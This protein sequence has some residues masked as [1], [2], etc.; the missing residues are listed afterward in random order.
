MRFTLAAA[1]LVIVVLAGCACKPATSVPTADEQV[2]ITVGHQIPT[3]QTWGA[4][5]IKNQRLFERHLD[6]LVPDHNI[7]VEW[8]N[9]ETGP[10][11]NN[12]MVARKIHIA[13]MGDMPLLANG[14]I[15]QSSTT[16]TSALVALDGKGA[17]GRNQAILVGHDSSIV[18]V[19][20]LD[21]KVIAV[22][23]GTSAH[24]MALDVLRQFDLLDR[25][26]LVDL[27]INVGA[28]AIRQG[29][30]DAVACWEPYPA[31]LT[32]K[33]LY[34]V[35]VGGEVTGIDYLDGVVANREWAE[36]NPLI[37]Q[38]FLQALIEAHQLMVRDHETAAR[39][40]HEETELPMD[41]CRE[42]APRLWFD[43]AVYARDRA[44]LQSSAEFLFAMGKLGEL[45]LE[46]F[47]DDSYLRRA[48]EAMNMPYLTAEELEGPWLLDCN[49]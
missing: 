29:K 17:G 47:I 40:F 20:D 22:P 5:A 8:F 27:P 49:F 44:T 32:G 4:L 3:S 39:I 33:G 46:R 36:S 35:L 24:R 41:I 14:S 21:G 15:G 19:A 13:F 45:D 34:R 1:I 6:Q 42:L 26:Q 7:R 18:E 16:Y 12:G 38:A 28:D 31:V 48:A 2:I 9:S 37:M 43:A 11:L 30:A 23:F 25:V 10:P